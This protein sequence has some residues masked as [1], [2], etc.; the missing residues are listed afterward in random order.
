MPIHA[1]LLSLTNICTHWICVKLS[2]GIKAKW[3]N[4]NGICPL[5][6]T[7]NKTNSHYIITGLTTHTACSTGQSPTCVTSS[8]HKTHESGLLM[9]LNTSEF[10]CGQSK[11]S[12]LTPRCVQG[13]CWGLSA[14]HTTAC[15]FICFWLVMTW[16]RPNG[17]Y[18]SHSCCRQSLIHWQKR[19]MWEDDAWDLDLLRALWF[20]CCLCEPG[21]WGK[22]Y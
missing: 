4:V 6:L 3:K 18:G 11:L 15:L 16:A 1:N 2:L 5:Q 9:L 12:S 13:R 10:W 19:V 14:L 17:R 21:G 22:L 8:A 7:R 20:S